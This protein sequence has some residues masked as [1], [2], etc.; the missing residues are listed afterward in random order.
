MTYRFLK[1]YLNPG[2][3]V[4]TDRGF[5]VRELLNPRQLTLKISSFLKGR[6][7]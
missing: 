5:T 1:R 2:D 6:S 4:M 7:S 3:V